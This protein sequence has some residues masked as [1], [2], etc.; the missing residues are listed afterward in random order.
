M[1]TN[2]Q[3]LP[4]RPA[5]TTEPP[6]GSNVARRITLIVL[7]FLVVPVALIFLVFPFLFDEPFAT[8]DELAPENIASL[9][10]TLVNRS[11]LDG[12]EDVGPYLAANADFAGLLAPFK[13]IP[14]VEQFPNARG[15]WL[16]EFRVLT[17][18]GRRG[19][20]RFYWVRDPQTPEIPARLR[21]QVGERKFEGGRA[22]TLI[23]AAE[24][25]KERGTPTR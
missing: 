19:R 17:K 3:H 10:V 23:K 11:E 8:V 4:P 25:A 18:D 16:G 24:A 20:I 13:S 14:E 22:D 7:G 1:H 5:G 12:G 6:G 15:P 9:R 21:F 2:G